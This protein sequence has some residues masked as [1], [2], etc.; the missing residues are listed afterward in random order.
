MG[1]S[2]SQKGNVLTF[3]AATFGLGPV[4]TTFAIGTIEF[5]VSSNVATDGP[6]IF[7]G[8]FNVGF[9]AI[10]DNAGVGITGSASFGSASVGAPVV[11]GLGL[12]GLALLAA[13][14]TAAALRELRRPPAAE[15]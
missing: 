1:S 7:S 3:E 4:A 14:F 13:L 10:F 8:A 9:D 6:D 11:P 5:R 15:A 2:V 12:P